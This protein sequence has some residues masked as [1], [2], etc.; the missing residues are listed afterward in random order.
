[1]QV[2]AQ[3]VIGNLQEGPRAAQT[4]GTRKGLPV[5]VFSNFPRVEDY[6]AGYVELIRN[7]VA[8]LEAA[9]AKR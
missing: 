3:I 2:D 1:M 9:W 7:N 5:A 8:R 4:L 6:G